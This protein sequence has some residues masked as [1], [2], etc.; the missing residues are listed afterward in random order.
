MF[1]KWTYN[2]VWI[3]HTGLV[4]EHLGY[5]ISISDILYHSISYE[6]TTRFLSYKYRKFFIK[7]P[8]KGSD[9]F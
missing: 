8:K 5:S 2:K 6:T 3:I 9:G 7:L 4:L 1:H